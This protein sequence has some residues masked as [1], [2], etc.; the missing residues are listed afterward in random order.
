MSQKT[1]TKKKT[2]APKKTSFQAALMECI[3]KDRFI[4][5]CNQVVNE[6]VVID[7]LTAA[8][9]VNERQQNIGVAAAW[10]IQSCGSKLTE[11]DANNIGKHAKQPVDDDPP[12]A[13]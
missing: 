3:G 9:S 4:A 13:A 10:F 12:K 5:L 7:K 6:G 8:E 11:T 1:T 2:A